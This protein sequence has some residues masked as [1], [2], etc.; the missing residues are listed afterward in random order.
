[1]Q[2]AANTVTLKYAMLGERMGHCGAI[3]IWGLGIDRNKP[4]Y[5]CSVCSSSVLSCKLQMLVGNDW[6]INSKR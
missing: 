3:R 2:A 6:E 5:R 4:A 1:M